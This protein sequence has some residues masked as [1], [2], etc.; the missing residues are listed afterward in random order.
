VG[1]SEAKEA[2]EDRAKYIIYFSFFFDF[3][4]WLVV[5]GVWS[6]VF[7]IFELPLP[8]AEKRP[9]TKNAI[10]KT[11]GEIGVGFWSIFM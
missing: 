1:G 11:R 4:W 9:K 6:V 3:F 7:S 10:K 2:T 8:I 5:G